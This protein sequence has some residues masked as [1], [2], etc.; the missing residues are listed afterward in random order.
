MT[1]FLKELKT[2]LLDPQAQALAEQVQ[3]WALPGLQIEDS[4]PVAVVGTGPPLLLLHG[5]DSSFL[6]FRRLAPL[7]VDRFQLFIPDLFGFGFSP[8]PFDVQYGPE[9]VLEHL[10]QVLDQLPE[11]SPV[12]VIGASMGGSVA[13]ELARRQPERIGSLLL[14]APAGLTGRPMPVPP[15]LDRF[16]A[17]FLSRPGVRRG[18]CRQAFADPDGQVGPPE[19]QIASL[20]LQC[21]GWAEALAAFAR[22]GG[23]AGCGDPL[24]SQPLHVIWGE[25][26]RILRAPLK[27]AAQA[28]LRDPVETFEAC[29]HLPHI[30]QPQQVAD[31]CLDHL[32]R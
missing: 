28:L 8:R 27:Q 7:L 13:V 24:P 30:D 20:H 31:R 18:L 26:D 15:L 25:N 9:P 23:F 11:E 17:W 4:F 3:W 2:G 32:L 6:E 14:L 29:G 16:G 10:E 19:E 1:F 22:T 12:G 21:P 5:F